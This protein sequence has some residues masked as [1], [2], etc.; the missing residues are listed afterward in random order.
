MGCR[1]PFAGPAD[2]GLANVA[3]FGDCATRKSNAANARHQSVL[4][5]AV[6]EGQ[7][8]NIDTATESFLNKAH[9]TPLLNKTVS[10]TDHNTTWYEVFAGHDV[11][12]HQSNMNQRELKSDC[13]SQLS[14]YSETKTSE[15]AKNET[16]Q[17]CD[18]KPHSSNTSVD[19]CSPEKKEP[20]PR[21]PN[22]SH[23]RMMDLNSPGSGPYA[24]SQR[25]TISPSRTPSTPGKGAFTFNIR[26]RVSPS[27]K[28]GQSEDH[29]IFLTATIDSDHSS[30]E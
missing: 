1:G 17:G 9:A 10:P 30:N 5:R 6:Q 4:Y 16:V 28:C 23:H 7:N 2:A 12:R 11:N 8:V 13:P 29:E 19:Q 21:T 18:E 3:H 27:R 14:K 26:A 20:E 22:H 25:F 15:A 24:L